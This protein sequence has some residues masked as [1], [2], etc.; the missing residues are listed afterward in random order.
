[1][2]LIRRVSFRNTT[3]IITTV[4]ELN[5]TDFPRP[6]L[7]IGFRGQDSGYVCLFSVFNSRLLH[8]F[9]FTEPVT[10]VAYLAVASAQSVIGAF[11][12]CLILGTN[13]GK[14]LLVDLE[15]DV[16]RADLLSVT[17][18]GDPVPILTIPADA[19]DQDIRNCHAE[20]TRQKVSFGL[21]LKVLQDSGSV[22]SLLPLP[23]LNCLAVGLC[24]GRL[25][26]YSLDH[27]DAFHLALPPKHESPL[28]SLAFLEPADDP[29]ACA[30]LWAFHDTPQMAIA[31]MHSLMF[32]RKTASDESH[33]TIRYQE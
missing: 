2:L 30:Y 31:V 29:K 23:V 14:T 17:R 7:A 8:F 26:L 10:S 9:E 19:T 15:L 5:L 27:L 11:D 22:L 21:E 33:T 16:L 6:V 4:V 13:S 32:G 18:V 20:A 12:G 25:V 3:T 24:D 1:M 28:I